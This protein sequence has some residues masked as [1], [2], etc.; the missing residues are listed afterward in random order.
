MPSKISDYDRKHVDEIIAGRGDWFSAK[1]IRLL[2]VCDH[3][4]FETIRSVYS[5]HVEAYEEW[6]REGSND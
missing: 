2:H 1:L 6:Q 5:D 4:N 3:D